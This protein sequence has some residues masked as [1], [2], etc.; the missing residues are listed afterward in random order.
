MVF[1]E[2]GIERAPSSIP[3]IRGLAMVIPGATQLT[4]IPLRPYLVCQ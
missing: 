1:S 2:A 3:L 4:W